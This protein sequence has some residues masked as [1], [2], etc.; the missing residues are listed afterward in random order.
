MV[1]VFYFILTIASQGYKNS[2]AYIATQ[3]PLPSTVS[4]F[5]RMVWEQRV[6]GIVMVTNCI[7]KGRVSSLLPGLL[8]FY[9]QI[10]IEA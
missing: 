1:T 8:L 5:W 7:E 10:L 4:D 9:F 6:K 2:R 3:G